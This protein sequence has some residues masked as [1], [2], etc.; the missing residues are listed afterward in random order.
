MWNMEHAVRLANEEWTEGMRLF[1]EMLLEAKEYDIPQPESIRR[2]PKWSEDHGDDFDLDRFRGGQEYWRTTERTKRAGSVVKTIIVNNGMLHGAD[3]M[4]V[5]W[6]GV[7]ATVVTELLEQAGYRVELYSARKAEDA[8]YTRPHNHASIVCLKQA[9]EPLDRSTML[10]SLSG[11][12][13]RSIYITSICLEKRPEELNNSCGITG[14]I[15][16]AKDLID[17]KA[18][19]LEKYVVDRES[20]MSWIK[21]TLE[22]LTAPPPPPPRHEPEGDVVDE[23]PAAPTPPPKPMS[24]KEF[25]KFMRDIDRARKQRIRTQKEG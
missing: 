23:V 6:R 15:T 12:F 19:L 16:W 20:A 21:S 10:N 22:T 1:E 7:A 5:T 11:W 18:V 14:Y 13:F 4:M 17:P 8:Y 25:N 3:P 2:T 24:D 9:S